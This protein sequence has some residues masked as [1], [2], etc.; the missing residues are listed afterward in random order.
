[1]GMKIEL[2]QEIEGSILDIGGGGEG[3]LGRLYC[4][5]VTAIDNCQEELDEAPGGYDKMLM[6]GTALTFEDNRFCNV[7]FFYTLM[8]MQREEQRQ[9]LREA[10]RVLR[11]GGRLYIWDAE[12]LSAYPEPF[13]AELDISLPGEQIHTTYGVVKMDTQDRASIEEMC[14]AAGLL[15]VDTRAQ[16]GHFYLHFRKK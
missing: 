12:I 2:V 3:I 13:C 15:A 9:A 7:T 14:V 4:S 11:P 6:D 8:Y 16:A 1:M 10:A 5:Q